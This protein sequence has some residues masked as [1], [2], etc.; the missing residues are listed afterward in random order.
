MNHNDYL[1]NQIEKIGVIVAYLLG[2][3][4]KVKDAHVQAEID[5]GFS[6][7]FDLDL[8][9]HSLEVLMAKVSNM[10]EPEKLNFLAQLLELEIENQFLTS[11]ELTLRKELLEFTNK[12]LEAKYADMKVATFFGRLKKD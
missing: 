2:F 6:E 9:S 10:V 7:L 3:K 5:K 12:H 1:I 4:G 11:D 8:K